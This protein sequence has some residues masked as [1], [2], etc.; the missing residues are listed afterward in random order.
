LDN[1]TIEKGFNYPFSNIRSIKMGLDMYLKAERSLYGDWVDGKK[2]MCERSKK[3]RELFPE[4]KDIKSGNLETT[5]VAIEIGYWRKANQIHQWFVDNVQEGNDNCE[6][7]SVERSKLEELLKIC[8]EIKKEA[9]MINDSVVNGYTI[10]KDG[11][12]PILKDGKVVLNKEVCEEK[13]PTQGGFFFGGEDYDEFYMQDIDNTIK[14][15]N[16]CLA[17]PDNW[18]FNYRS[19]W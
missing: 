6:A 12:K 2:R 16:R 17:L 15:I 13:L 4:L 14:I 8:K 5:E 10:D 19:S 3:I 9:K 18:Y 7:H 11:K 1:N